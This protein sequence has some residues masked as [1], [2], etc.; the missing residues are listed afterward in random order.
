MTA[1]FG[2]G[3]TMP[4]RPEVSRPADQTILIATVL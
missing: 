4:P 1:N 3:K 2:A